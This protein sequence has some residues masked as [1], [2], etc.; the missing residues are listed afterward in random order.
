VK[1]DDAIRAASRRAVEQLPA[2]RQK[3]SGGLAPGEHV[4][5][6][7]PFKKPDGGQEWMWIEVTSWQ[8]SRIR[9]LLRN[10][11]TGI[12]G[13]HAGETVEVAESDVF[14]YIHTLPDGTQVGNETGKLIEKAGR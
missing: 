7:G 12:P 13:L 14:D 4:M 2:L 9:G 11:P 3:F 6:K 10:E 1:H 5:V 8:G